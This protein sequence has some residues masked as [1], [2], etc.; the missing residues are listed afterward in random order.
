MWENWG[1]EQLC[2]RQLG[3]VTTGCGITGFGTS[4]GETTGNLDYCVRDNC[5]LG[6]LW[7]GQMVVGTTMRQKTG[8]KDY[9]VWDN[10]GF[11]LLC[12]RQLGVGTTVCKT[13]GAWD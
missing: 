6:Q 5:R 7:A 12:M 13:T 1:L 3:V 10:W 4:V 11:G 9:W 8:G 2:V